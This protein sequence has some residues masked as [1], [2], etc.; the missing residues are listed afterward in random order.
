MT[1]RRRVIVLVAAAV[2]T[3]IVLGSAATYV[4]VRH[5]L[6]ASVDTRLRSLVDGLD[7]GPSVERTDR[8]GLSERESDQIR[9]RVT[10]REGRRRLR[11]LLGPEL[12]AA[13]LREA[14]GQ[15]TRDTREVEFAV[16]RSQLDLPAGYVQFVS[17]Q[18]A[19]PE[20][21]D[22][23]KQLLPVTGDTKAVARGDRS[24]F[25]ADDTIAGLHV[26]VLTAPVEGGAVQAAVAMD[27]VDNTLDRL[28]VVLVLVSL[29][30]VGL[31]AGLALLVARAAL[32]PV[33]TL[34]ATTEQVSRTRDLGERLTVRGGDE[35]ARL[36]MSFNRMMGA[37]EASS[38]AQRQLVA[39]ASHELRTPLASLLMNIELLGERGRLAA[40]DRER[41]IADLTEQVHELT[42]LV[43][44]L[45]DLARDEPTGAEAEDV[46]LDELVA[47][48]VARAERHAPEQRFTLHGEPTTVTGV[49]ARL[50]RAVNNLLDNAVKWNP[51]GEPIE[52]AVR[53]G[54][55]SVRDH[56]PGFAADD[57]PHVF[58]RF[59][60]ATQ[61]RGL[62]GAGLGLAIVRQV[63]DAHGGTIEATNAAGGGALLRMR[64]PH[65]GALSK[66]L[67]V[68]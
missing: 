21:P 60:R 43:G 5:D 59:Y 66:S 31:A 41:V 37:L 64:L 40:V 3:A 50:E 12:A 30:G 28:A 9:R 53:D 20:P 48:A 16:P 65:A 32:T 6:H 34:T 14:A 22:G 2:A 45:V 51:S 29:A 44:D 36:A 68:S 35:L 62:P 33:A 58:D 1:F 17:S 18:G 23:G 4:I 7:V 38:H 47:E 25:F 56:G 46:R 26:R 55:V 39:D 67:P 49:P 57:L 8:A 54:Q 11:A 24:A 19:A 10:S 63:A 52:V 13:F 61:S 27:A 42:V 15:G